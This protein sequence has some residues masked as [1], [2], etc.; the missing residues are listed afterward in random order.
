MR[1][2][3]ALIAQ[4]EGQYLEFKSTLEGPPGQKRSRSRRAIRD[5]IAEAVAAFANA[6]GGTLI[7]GVE[8]DKTVTGCDL[9]EDEIATMLAVPQQRL[10]PPLA[11][12]IVDAHAG[13][14]LL[15]FE[16]SAAAGA[17]MVVGDGF[18][19]RIGEEV[20][21]ESQAS[22]E[23]IKARART[24]SGEADAVPNA[25][26]DQLDGDLIRRAQTA[27]GLASAEPAD[28]L[29]Q[30][31]LADRRGTDVVLR[32]G[33]LLL[34]AH[35]QASIPLPNCG[36]RVIQVRGTQRETGP[37]L[38][39][40][41]L[42]RFE[43]AVPQ[44]IDRTYELLQRHIAK[45]SR[46]HDL[47]FRETPEYP[48]FAWQEALVNAVAHRDYRVQGR[49]VEVWM[50]EDRLE[51]S[52]PGALLPGIELRA[53]MQRE[54]VHESRNPRMARV[55]A[56]LGLMREQGEGIPRMFEE[57]ERSLLHLPELSVNGNT[58]TV[59]LRNQPIF[60]STDPE[61]VRHVEA[62][63]I[64]DR[65]RRA[66]VAFQGGA[67][68]SADYQSINRVDRDQAYRELSELVGL[69][70]LESSGKLGRGA[71]YRV[72]DSRTEHAAPRRAQVIAGRMR[73]QGHIRNA[74]YREVFGVDR[75]AAKA[76]LRALTT[77]GV[78]IRTGERRG[79]KY[80]PGAGFDSWV[81]GGA[82]RP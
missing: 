30:R 48:T 76:D 26:M 78:L 59:V 62:L 74:D 79:T 81:R 66:M 45:S 33:A 11:A 14:R 58:F 18:P 34:F 61:W 2:L 75:A 7:V 44:V 24:E 19:R 77:S 8:D 38:N 68:S 69:G 39:T 51:V 37:R 20:I 29:I 27:A 25:R 15:V 3:G 73:T 17:V 60:T 40:T 47:F 71:T 21:Q 63:P 23:A 12:G 32:L 28:Y 53:L 42:G 65:Q 82:K 16:V 56:E 70:L 52:S 80:L 54:R 5:D 13:H 64:G 9:P 55:L 31:R 6:E 72:P 57:M 22:I 67:F 10:V 4:G 49:G 43:G 50:F 41:E 46:L 1:D 36:I 35:D